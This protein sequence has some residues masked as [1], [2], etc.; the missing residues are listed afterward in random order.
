M[1]RVFER[2]DSESEYLRSSWVCKQCRVV[3]KDKPWMGSHFVCSCE[4]IFLGSA[5][6][7]PH[8]ENCHAFES[9]AYG[10]VCIS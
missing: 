5:E 2:L 3:G 1:D 9:Y 8:S 10:N 4:L 6:L 7:V